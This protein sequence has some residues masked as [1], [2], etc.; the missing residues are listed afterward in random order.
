MHA[1]CLFVQDQSPAY[2][3]QY[4]HE[5]G[6]AQQP[7]PSQGARGGEQAIYS[8]VPTTPSLTPPPSYSYDNNIDVTRHSYTPVLIL[9]LP[10]LLLVHLL[11][12]LHPCYCEQELGGAYTASEIRDMKEAEM[13]Y[14]A[15]KKKQ[16][17]HM[18]R[19]ASGD[20]TTTRTSG[21][22]S[23]GCNIQ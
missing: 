5:E 14:R 23:E 16:D 21:G 9:L 18:R 7:P 17:K 8:Q 11:L 22:K 1:N 19:G 2:I 15:Q 4:W 3:Q 20:A 10:L 12:L 6:L 13:Q